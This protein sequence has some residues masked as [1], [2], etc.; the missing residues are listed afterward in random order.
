VSLQ[1]FLDDEDAIPIPDPARRPKQLQISN[2]TDTAYQL[3]K[4]H[5]IKLAWG[6]D[7]TFD[8]NLPVGGAPSWPR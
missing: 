2:G 4:K 3:A 6:T 8:A 7:T 1:P 5:Q